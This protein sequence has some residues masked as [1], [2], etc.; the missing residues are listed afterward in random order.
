MKKLS[1][2]ISL[3]YGTAMLTG[4]AST[5]T[6][7]K[8]WTVETFQR[9]Q[10]A[11][12][13]PDGYYRLGRFY[14]G[15]N[16]L[17][18]AAEAY[19][20]ALAI[21]PAFSDA[22][23][24][25]GTIY[26]AQGKYDQALVEFN[27]VIA[28]SP[29]AAHPYNN[30]GY[31]HLLQGNYAEAVAAFTQAI[32]IEPTDRKVRNNLNLALAKLDAPIT[33]SPAVALAPESTTSVQ[34]REDNDSSHV[35][36]VAATAS[37]A[38]VESA[39]KVAPTAPV[40]SIA[41]VAPVASVAKVAP[42]ATV[43]PVA[44]VT[45]SNKAYQMATTSIPPKVHGVIDQTPANK[46]E[47]KVVGHQIADKTSD[48]KASHPAKLAQPAYHPPFAV[49]MP[50][51]PKAMTIVM[52]SG[53]APTRIEKA[54]GGQAKTW[55][56]KP[57]PVSI[58]MLHANRTANVAVAEQAAS[59]AQRVMSPSKDVV[60]KEAPIKAAPSRIMQSASLP[61]KRNFFFEVSNG[62]GIRHFAATVSSML[63]SKGLPKANLSDQKPY[64]QAHTVI[65]YRKGYLF[66]AAR[67][68]RHLRSIQHLAFVVENKNLP[69]N[70]DVKLILGKDLSG[71]INRIDN[72]NLIALASR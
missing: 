13:R 39:A 2:A 30:L 61:G 55:G 17:D 44:S 63:F 43:A 53:N 9:I 31:L 42:A 67:L 15:Q 65:Q 38:P 23:N 11:T 1:L 59:K 47:I 14:Q 27:A 71:K 36:A 41:S 16:R 56:E 22:H 45:S 62:N 60:L 72:S 37:V 21:D 70:T 66:E 19:R 5:T 25:L 69:L 7:S 54:S 10:H 33:S 24:G 64:N 46:P 34:L 26:A 28:A 40:A 51:N 3:I 52:T 12:N 48:D 35:A 49:L 32:Q 6:E 68:S 20:K 4:C 18:L 50:P 58:R 8:N 57:S 29:G